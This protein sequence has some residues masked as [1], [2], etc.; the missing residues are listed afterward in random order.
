MYATN[1]IWQLLLHHYPL[2]K[3][4]IP[5]RIRGSAV[6]V[7]VTVKLSAKKR[8]LQNQQRTPTNN[9]SACHVARFYRSHISD[10]II[11]RLPRG[12][13]RLYRFQLQCSIHP[14]HH[15]AKKAPHA[16]KLG[17]M[18]YSKL[19]SIPQQCQIR[20]L[21]LIPPQVSPYERVEWAKR[22]L[23]IS[24]HCSTNACTVE[25]LSPHHMRKGGRGGHNNRS[26]P[27]GT[28]ILTERFAAAWE[29]LITGR[30]GQCC[31]RGVRTKR[32]RIIR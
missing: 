26:L 16:T 10:Q 21:W 18:V 1:H 9:C 5:A 8:V 13:I 17:R 31:P 7:S 32:S 24:P 25:A 30:T 20:P 23:N 27:F 3:A 11:Y 14:N 15:W 12:R 29:R 28:F 19:R 4:F 22:S 6:S 2:S